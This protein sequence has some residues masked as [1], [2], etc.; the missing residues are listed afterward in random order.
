MSRVRTLTTLGLETCGFGLVILLIIANE[1]LDLPPLIFGAR[2]T[3]I[4]ISEILLETGAI[5]LW[6]VG[7]TVASWRRNQRIA[8]LEKLLL[9]CASCRRVNV[10]GRWLGF[11]AYIKQRDHLLTSHG[12]CPTCY[13]REVGDLTELPELLQS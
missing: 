6:G 9:I 11:E 5:L 1:Y 12:V 3:P 13:E 10:D 2:P 8:R 4:R 7:I